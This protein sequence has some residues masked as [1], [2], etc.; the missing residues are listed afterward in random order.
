MLEESEEE[1]EMAPE[2]VP[3]VVPEEVPVE[4]AMITV[5]EAAPS[6]SHGAP[7]ASSPPPCTVAAMGTVAGAAAGLEVLL[8]HPTLYAPYDIPLDEVVSTTH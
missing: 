1:L 7:A 5:Q 8:G 6:P 3:E 4:G 2:P